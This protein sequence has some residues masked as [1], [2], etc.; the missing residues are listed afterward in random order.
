MAS[1][2][3]GPYLQMTSHGNISVRWVTDV[4]TN[5]K[6]WWGL[7]G[8]S[9]NFT[10]TFINNSSVTEHE[11]RISG[12]QPN[13][14]YYYGV[15][16]TTQSLSSGSTNYFWTAPS[17]GYSGHSRFF[18]IADFGTA[19]SAETNVRN[20]FNT[21]NSSASPSDKVDLVFM[22]GDNAYG[23]GTI[24]NFDSAVFNGSNSYKT[25]IKKFNMFLLAGNHDYANSGFSTA[26]ATLNWPIFNLFTHPSG[27]ECGG[28]VSNT[29]RYYSFNW[30]NVHI[31]SL[32]GYRDSSNNNTGMGSGSAMYKWLEN[33][34]KFNTKKWT[35]LFTH[36]PPFSHGTHNSDT[37]TELSNLRT[38]ITPLIYRY[39][40]DLV[41]NGHSHVYER[42]YFM[43][44]FT[45]ISSAWSSGFISQTGLGDNSSG[46]N[47]PYDKSSGQ[48]GTTFVVIGN[49]GQGGN[50]ST[51]GTWP[52][53]AM[54][55][56]NRSTF[57]SLVIDF[58]TDITG[59]ANG[60]S[61]MSVKIVG[62][63]GLLDSFLIKK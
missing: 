30:G 43:K 45:G 5:T 61:Y 18:V 2:T 20:A 29:E 11:S 22:V 27:S 19:D 14:K 37:A 23:S 25:E 15:G 63:G 55:S 7:S 4:A 44:N 36:F 41:M 38:I 48:S 56:Y 58:N 60:G 49:G 28:V 8:S 51:S 47:L 31:I 57:A 35:I 40:V 21:F 26:Q 34:L 53:S 46:A 52:H 24:T 59:T 12:L 54:I 3:R 13:S 33:D 1:I 17:I 9:I 39:N 16:S 62:I 10:N 50:V 6:V 42:T 32:D